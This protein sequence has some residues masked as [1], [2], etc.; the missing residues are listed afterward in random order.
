[1]K[2]RSLLI[3]VISLAAVAFGMPNS[4][5]AGEL[6]QQLVQESTIEQLLK[7]GVLRVGM[8]TFVP[9]AMRDKNGK[10]I[11]FEI[12]VAMRLAKDIG[13]E[14]EFVPTKWAGI[15]PALLTGKFDV[16]IG[17]MGIRPKR[18]L[19]VNFDTHIFGQ[20][21]GYIDLETDKL[22]GFILHGPG[23]KGGHAHSEGSFLQHRRMV[24]QW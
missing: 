4:G 12:D 7:R 18:A 16:V 14:V 9:W 2:K 19:K 11:G 1:M 13:V 24:G 15:I 23:D 10:L 17:G 22:A 8:S 20:L 21:F 6:Q 5:F 3:I